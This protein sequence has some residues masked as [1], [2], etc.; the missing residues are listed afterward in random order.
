MARAPF[1][2]LVL[3]YRLNNGG[4]AEFA[5]FKRSD[6]GYWQFIAGGGEANEN[7]IETARRET[8]EESGLSK[9]SDFVRLDS[10]A[11]VPVEYVAGTFLWGDDIFV[12]PEHAFAVDA[13]QQ[14]IRLSDEHTEYAW[15]GF[16]DA[17]GKLKWDSNRNALWELNERL[18]RAPLSE[19]S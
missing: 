18:E 9:E 5:V 14:T 13:G 15:C 1:Q 19:R 17:M 16:Q 4:E 3:P 12:V 2:V 7:P 6:D 11:T 8:W 10:M